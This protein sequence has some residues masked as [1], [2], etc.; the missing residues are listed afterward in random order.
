MY[1]GTL[2]RIARENRSTIIT[3]GLFQQAF[4]TYTRTNYKNGNPY[5]AECHYPTI[6]MWSGDTTNHSEHYLHSTYIDN[7]FTNLIGIIPTLEDRLEIRPLV[8]DN[9]TYFAIENLPYHG[10]F[11]SAENSNAMLIVRLG[12]LFS[13]L[14]DQNGDHYTNFE[15]KKGLS[16]YS[17]GSLL[18]NQA[19]LS[20]L[21]VTLFEG[22]ETAAR[23]AAQPTYQNILI[24]P[25]APWGLPNI[26][27]DYTF[28]S[29][30]DI[31]PYEAWKMID[32]LLWYDT[33][34]DNRW[35][36]NQSETPF[37]TISVTLP[38]PRQMNSISLAIYDDTARGG[39]IACPHGIIIHD[40]NGSVLASRNPWTS[41][42][43]NALNTILF[44]SD[45][46]NNTNTTTASSDL[47]VETDYLSI[48]L[49]NALYYSVAVSEIQIWV[50]S[51]PGPRYEAED[52]LL[53][54]FIGSFEGRKTG[55]NCTIEKNGVRFGEGGWA[56]I[57]DVK[58][59]G[60][61]GGMGKLTVVGGGTG[62]LN[63][64]MNF[65]G[66]RT[67][68]FN[69]GDGNVTL[70]EVPFLEGGNVVTMF[71][72]EGEPFVDAIIVG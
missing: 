31:S 53:G 60:A 23:L 64:Q 17:N 44:N 35:T 34:P 19:T 48:T 62:R 22:S 72:V 46:T 66:N 20:P 56:E 1:L 39:V 69:G 21:N 49:L 2:A 36:N 61:G 50:A 29:N 5:T 33:T 28:S 58:M 16:I 51:N 9:W 8:P 10:K 54:T 41:C 15:H 57:A 38:R 7:F 67:V 27:S 45:T 18:H 52:A 14:W 42:T 32:G 4:D 68:S 63:V 6:D 11:L 43:P 59:R 25:N 26:S 37:N 55:L 40:R 47:T 24:N 30:G 71:Q 65:L 70:E 13:I 12:S 3:P